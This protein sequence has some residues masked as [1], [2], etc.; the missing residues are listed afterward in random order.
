MQIKRVIPKT[1]TF[2]P[3]GGTSVTFEQFQEQVSFSTTDTFGDMV[4]QADL[5]VTGRFKTAHSASLRTVVK[6]FTTEEWASIAGLNYTGATDTVEGKPDW[7]TNYGKVVLVG[8]DT[9]VDKEIVIT[10]NRTV[11]A[12]SGD[13]N[14]SKDNEVTLG[15][16]FVA[17]ALADGSA[18]YTF[19]HRAVTP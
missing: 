4:S 15:L 5:M 14:F 17:M 3:E 13:I 11:P 6:S 9:E 2:T 12:V 7:K 10:I 18:A 1:L 16:E 19:T 8:Y